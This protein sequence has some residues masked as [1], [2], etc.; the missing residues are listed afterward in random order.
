VLFSSAA[1]T[2]G[3]AGQGNY[4]AA[5]AF[6]D[7]LGRQRR[8]A[9]LPA[10]SLAWG[11][12]AD[13]SV[14]TSQLDQ[15]GRARMARGGVAGLSAEHGLALLDLALARDEALLVP[16]RLDIAGWRIQASTAAGVPALLRGLAG[17][18][19][20][21][22]ASAAGPE[23]GPQAA[24]TLRE[25]LVARSRPERERMLLDLVRAHA[26]AVLG[27]PSADAIEATRAF[28][29]LGLDSLTAL[30]LRNRLNAATGLALPATLIFDCPTLGA[31][32]SYLR[33]ELMP[34]QADNPEP[35]LTELSQLESVLSGLQP[36]PGL[37]ENVT[38]RLQ[39]MLSNWIEADETAAPEGGIEFQSASLDEVFEFLDEDI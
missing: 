21:R 39:A 16:A 22:P 19:I 8:A 13:A 30:E 12:W 4:A 26:A 25:R 28:K 14:M 23:P 34:D 35:V 3:S 9:G 36:D 7:G 38:R 10:V 37:R 6:L 18:T 31:V 24:Q 32:A 5:N 17:G 29:D 27:H 15:T 2:F 33:A 1:G 20:R 11:L